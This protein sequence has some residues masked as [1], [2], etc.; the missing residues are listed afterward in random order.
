[1]TRSEFK[2]EAVE[3]VTKR[4]ASFERSWDTCDGAAAMGMCA[5]R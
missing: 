1:M 2:Q 3:T 5:E 4:G